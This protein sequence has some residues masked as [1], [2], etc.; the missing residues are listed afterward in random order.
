[1]LILGH[2]AGVFNLDDAVG[3]LPE[4]F[5]YFGSSSVGASSLTTDRCPFYNRMKATVWRMHTRA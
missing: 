3:I 4:K 1:M 5:Q 2:V